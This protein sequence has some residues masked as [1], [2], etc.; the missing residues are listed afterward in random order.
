MTCAAVTGWP[1][2][3]DHRAATVAI[4]VEDTDHKKAA[5][6]V[7]ASLRAGTMRSR[8]NLKAV[9]QALPLRGVGRGQ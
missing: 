7:A 8:H 3:I 5:A 9:T 4:D 2:V 6:I 1:S